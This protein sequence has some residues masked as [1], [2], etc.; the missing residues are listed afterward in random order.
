[1]RIAF[2]YLIELCEYLTAQLITINNNK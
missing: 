2:D 1:L